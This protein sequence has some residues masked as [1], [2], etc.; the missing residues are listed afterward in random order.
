MVSLVS[1]SH[2]VGRSV[3]RN[4]YLA[5]VSAGPRPSHFGRAQGGAEQRPERPGS[6]VRVAQ[7]WREQR[8]RIRVAVPRGR[9]LR[10]SSDTRTRY[11][12]R[13]LRPAR[14]ERG[15]HRK[16]VRS[17]GRTPARRIARRA[18]AGSCHPGPLAPLR[19][20]ESPRPIVSTHPA[21]SHEVVAT[22]AHQGFHRNALSASVAPQS[23]PANEMRTAPV[24]LRCRAGKRPKPLRSLAVDRAPSCRP[25]PPR[26]PSR[27]RRAGVV[28]Q[29][30]AGE[31]GC[32]C[33]P[34]HRALTR[35]SS[36]HA[37]RS[38]RR[39]R[40]RRL[41]PGG[42]TNRVPDRAGQAVGEQSVLVHVISRPKPRVRRAPPPALCTS[43]ADRTADECPTRGM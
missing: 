4:R 16:R 29:G 33:R 23:G 14:G 21:P 10:R 15:R 9:C 35:P 36:R 43:S 6:V 11:P 30:R 12:A 20:A 41:E 42:A 26:L 8:C 28:R 32:P 19:H 17:R 22:R 38:P 31:E 5:Q 7:R 3:A 37:L 27:T 40:C 39:C 2:R 34:L 1:P 13:A 25:Y 24:D 18:I